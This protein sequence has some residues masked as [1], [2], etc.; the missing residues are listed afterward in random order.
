[1]APQPRSACVSGS[2]WTARG[3]GA[4]VR[5]VLHQTHLRPY[6][7]QLATFE[8]ALRRNVQLPTQQET[9]TSTRPQ[10]H[11]CHSRSEDQQKVAERQSRCFHHVIRHV[12]TSSNAYPLR[13]TNTPVAE[14]PRA[15][16]NMIPHVGRNEPTAQPTDV[17]GA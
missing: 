5:H 4:T 2:D 11:R 10:Q 16:P 14:A 3:E 1:M 12:R 9:W 7:L 6:T 8:K 17:S 13:S 15:V